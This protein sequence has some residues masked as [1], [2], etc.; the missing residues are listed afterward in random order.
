M[1]REAAIKMPPEERIAGRIQGFDIARALAIFGMITVNYR[2]TFPI[3]QDSP[4]WLEWSANQINGRA[5]ALFVFLAG[6]GIS[7]LSRKARLSGDKADIREDRVNLLRRAAFLLVIGF[8]FRQYWE[9]DILHFYGVY[10]L[11]AAAVLTVPSSAL[12]LFAFAAT[13]VFPFLYYLVPEYLGIGYWA[14]T[15]A[16]TPRDIAIDLFFQGY[17][18]VMPW[19]AFMIAGMIVGRLDLA[20]KAVRRRL[21]IGGVILAVA[22]EAIAYLFLNMGVFKLTGDVFPRI[23]LEEASAILDTAP[24]PPMPLFIAAGTGWAM[25]AVSLCLWFG[26][27]FAGRAWITPLVHTGQLALTIYVIHGTIGIWA[28]GWAGVKPSQTLAWVI[29]YSALLYAVLIIL[30]T[31]WRRRY[32]RGP[33]EAIMRRLTDSWKSEI[34]PVPPAEAS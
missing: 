18:P 8:W 11:V 21:L 10:L 26:E 2:S 15:N 27:R 23:D 25:A 20:D 34:N 9:Y 33:V 14:T 31:L 7:L 16:F 28:V 24:Y 17:H 13:I 6:I 3:T 5:A 29:G 30:A 32:E 19:V 12:L 4:E 1:S 22:A